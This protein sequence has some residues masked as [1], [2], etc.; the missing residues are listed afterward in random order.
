MLS[1]FL[2][3]TQFNSH[4]SIISFIGQGVIFFRS[5]TYFG[6]LLAILYTVIKI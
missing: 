3:C 2:I 6:I 4:I 1:D 5:L